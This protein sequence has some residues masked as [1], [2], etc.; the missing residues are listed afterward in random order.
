MSYVLIIGANSDIAQALARQYA[1]NGFN[2]YLAA[3][4]SSQLDQFA[5]EIR[6]NTQK[7][8]QCLEIDILDYPSHL[9][10][11]EG[12]PDKPAGVISAVGYLGSQGEGQEKFREAQKISYL[13]QLRKITILLSL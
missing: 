4:N 7:D 6:L 5:A 3:R 12:L 1:N 8:V 11:Y 10:F 9:P 13:K 2:L